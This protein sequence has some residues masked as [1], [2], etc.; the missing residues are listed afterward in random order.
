[1]KKEDQLRIDQFLSKSLKEHTDSPQL[2]AEFTDN[3][4]EKLEV[5]Q[6]SLSKSYKPILGWK[7]KAFYGLFFLG[8]IIISW[9]LIGNADV[10]YTITVPQSISN[11]LGFYND[12]FTSGDNLILITVSI[13]LGIWSLVLLD[14]L[15]NRL[16][17]G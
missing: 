17:L 8:I 12:F 5:Y 7:F 2:S 3:V 16:T 11:L 6:S 13:S 4:M 9:M 10:N 14:K 15:L 1:M